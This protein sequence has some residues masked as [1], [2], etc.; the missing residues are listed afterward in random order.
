ML[1]SA[2]LNSVWPLK[3]NVGQAT[4]A[5]KRHKIEIQPIRFYPLTY[6]CASPQLVGF[7]TPGCLYGGFEVCACVLKQ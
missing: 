7:C 1:E 3:P 2:E 5:G 6:V 4:D